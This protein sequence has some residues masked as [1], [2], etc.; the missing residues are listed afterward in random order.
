V[1]DG[2]LV[3]PG[4]GAAMHMSGPAVLVKPLSDTELYAIAQ[5]FLPG[6]VVPLRV[7]WWDGDFEWVDRPGTFTVD[8]YGST[9]SMTWEPRPVWWKRV[10]RWPRNRWNAWQFDRGTGC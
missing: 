4:V 9:F 8:R 1:S 7:V 2:R 5:R 6:R 3:S 10:L